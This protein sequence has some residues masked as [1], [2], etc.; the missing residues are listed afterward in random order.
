MIFLLQ[1]MP[2]LGRV[3]LAFGLTSQSARVRD[4]GDFEGLGLAIVAAFCEKTCLMH[5]HCSTAVG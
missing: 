4:C 5:I 1:F 2:C 3:P